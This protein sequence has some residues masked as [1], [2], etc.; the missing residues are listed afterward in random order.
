[1]V[2]LNFEGIGF[3]SYDNPQSANEAVA[4]MNGFKVFKKRLKVEIKKGEVNY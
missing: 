3:V 1:M 4:T 2:S